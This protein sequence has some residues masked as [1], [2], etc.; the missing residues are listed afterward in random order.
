MA[1]IARR[2]IGDDNSTRSPKRMKVTAAID[3]ERRICG[4][5]EIVSEN[6]LAGRSA[7]AQAVCC[8]I[9]FD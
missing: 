4:R 7:D 1:M 8:S 3:H 5:A 9:D 6:R 2:K